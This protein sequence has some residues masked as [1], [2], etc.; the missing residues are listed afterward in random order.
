MEHST[1]AQTGTGVPCFCGPHI[2]VY[3]RLSR[4]CPDPFLA[5]VLCT[6]VH[7]HSMDPTELLP[8]ASH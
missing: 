8:D 2:L 6:L 4:P 5:L 3:P 1:G 7:S